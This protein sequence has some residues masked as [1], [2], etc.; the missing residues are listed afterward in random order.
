MEYI[1]RGESISLVVLC[2]ISPIFIHLKWMNEREIITAQEYET[3]KGRPFSLGPDASAFQIGDDKKVFCNQERFQIE[4]S[5]IT[6]SKRIIEICL[7]TLRLSEPKGY[8]AVG[9]NAQMDFTFLTEA[10][11]I[12]FGNTFVPL[13]TWED[14][15]P[16]PRVGS[17]NIQEHLPNPTIDHPRKAINI[18]SIGEDKQTKLPLVR[19]GVNYHHPINNFDNVEKVLERAAELYAKFGEICV[20]IFEEKL[21]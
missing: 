12:R 10:D 17:F 9:V 21:A 7:N 8:A 5:D 19:I 13:E 3:A 1:K 15:I 4:S 11:A 18:Q 14:L 6:D 16:S 2:N 20:M